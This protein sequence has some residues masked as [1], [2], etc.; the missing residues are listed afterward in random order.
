LVKQKV[1]SR[2]L[3]LYYFITILLAMFNTVFKFYRRY[4]SLLY[5]VF[6]VRKKWLLDV[7]ARESVYY[8]RLLR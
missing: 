3:E 7:I 1:Q 5:L 8:S 4:Q 6:A 2:V